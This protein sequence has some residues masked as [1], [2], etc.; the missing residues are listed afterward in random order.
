[1]SLEIRNLTAGYGHTEVLHGVDVTVEA[2]RITAM[3]GPNGAGKTT[4]L[5][6]IMGLVKCRSGSIM[7]KVDSR[8]EDL[9]LSGPHTRVKLGICMVPE[10]GRVFQKMTVLEN[11]K[12]AA[13]TI[14]DRTTIAK[15]MEM[16]FQIFPILDKRRNQLAGTMSGGEQAMLAIG[17]ALML[18]PKLILLDEPSLGLAP[19]VV[20]DAYSKLREINE[21]GVTLFIVEQNVD[22]ALSVATHLYVLSQGRI[23]F[24]GNPRDIKKET[25]FA[26]YYA[27]YGEVAQK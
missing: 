8:T 3:I 23:V 1:M 5:K 15:N 26:Q 11:L 6:T 25:L 17:K 13:Y 20:A 10:T 22:K 12:F 21:L 7:Y 2:G 14:K 18:N 16:V 9:K 24:S 19:K 4:L 27:G